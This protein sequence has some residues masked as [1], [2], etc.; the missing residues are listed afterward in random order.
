MSHLEVRHYQSPSGRDPIAKF[1]DK[2]P[3][4][5]AA[6]CSVVIGWLESGEIEEHPKAREHLDGD[7][8]ELKARH[9]GEQF[10]VLYAVDGDIVYLL[11]PI[12]KKTRKVDRRDIS[13]ARTRF[14]EVR[15]GRKVP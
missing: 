7:I 3:A 6:K 14:D 10:R 15:Q 8:W 5:A 9:D 1:L 11:V 4:K 13:R 2:L 12:H